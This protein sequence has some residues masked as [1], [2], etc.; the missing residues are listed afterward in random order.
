MDPPVWRFMQLSRS[1]VETRSGG[2]GQ[3][4]IK[5]NPQTWLM[6]CLCMWRRKNKSEDSGYGEDEQVDG[7]RHDRTKNSV[8]CFQLQGLRGLQAELLR[9]SKL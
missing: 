7:Y 4:R 3:T 2:H 6:D 8:E 5:V 9:K 1:Q